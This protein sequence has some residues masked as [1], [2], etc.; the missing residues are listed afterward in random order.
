ML[1]GGNYD[2][3]PEGGARATVGFW[4][5]RY[6]TFGVYAR[7]FQLGGEA[8]TNTIGQSGEFLG[9]RDYRAGDALRHIHWKGWAKTGKPIVKEF[10]DTYFPRYGLV[11]DNCVGPG[12][13]VL[14]EEAVSVA[15]SFAVAIDTKRCLLDLMFIKDEAIVMTAGRGLAKTEKVLEVLAG[16]EAER[17]ENFES[18][19]RLVGSYRDELSCCLCVFPGW[20]AVRA[21]FVRQLARSG[22]DVVCLILC[23]DS[24]EGAR[25][26]EQ[27]PVPCRHLLLDLGNVQESL[28]TL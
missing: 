15:A 24:D 25:Q 7:G 10:E 2:D 4:F 14:F 17:E 13:E 27:D 22:L 16:V 5:N 23:R 26:L 3:D 11:L 12:D 6:Q 21:E 18:L 9:L 8:V 1:F 20:A 19:Q 28:M